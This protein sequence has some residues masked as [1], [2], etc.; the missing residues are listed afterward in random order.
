MKG[1]IKFKNL[2][3]VFRQLIS[4]LKPEPERVNIRVKIELIN[5]NEIEK[6]CLD[7][8]DFE[9]YEKMMIH[10]L[11]NEPVK[12]IIVLSKEN[13]EKIEKKYFNKILI[14]LGYNLNVIFSKNHGS[15]Y[16]AATN[17]NGYSIPG[18]SYLVKAIRKIN[19]G[20]AVFAGKRFAPGRS[21]LH[22]RI[23]EGKKHW[24]I[25]SHIDKFN[26][27]NL[28]IKEVKHS[29]SGSGKGDYENGTRFFLESL[30]YYF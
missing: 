14:D 30:K 11:I 4:D 16:E 22:I 27:L 19:K 5:K 18:W 23:F 13:K 20:L 9:S 1:R 28:N 21:R 24:Y 29:H 7:K 2:A 6:Y 15:D 26:W 12:E 17:I 3:F 8:N 25:I 10:E